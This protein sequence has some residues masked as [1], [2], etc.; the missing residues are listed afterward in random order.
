[1]AR[2]YRAYNEHVGVPLTPYQ[3]RRTASPTTSFRRSSQQSSHHGQHYLDQEY[4]RTYEQNFKGHRRDSHTLSHTPPAYATSSPSS[5][6]SGGRSGRLYSD[7]HR[8]RRHRTRCQTRGRSR[9]PTRH[10]FDEREANQEHDRRHEHN[11]SARYRERDRGRSPTSDGFQDRNGIHSSGRNG[12]RSSSANARDEVFY[13]RGRRSPC[14]ESHGDQEHVL[15]SSPSLLPL[16]KMG[17]SDGIAIKGIAQQHSCESGVYYVKLD[18]D[19]AYQLQLLLEMEMDSEDY[20]RQWLHVAADLQDEL[21][22]DLMLDV[23]YGD[24]N[25]GRPKEVD[26]LALLRVTMT[27]LV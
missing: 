20:P 18:D 19:C 22:S 16:C 21:E 2:Q 27:T 12:Q 26:W 3:S 11:P 15:H 25:E 6:S 9:S 14:E 23:M 4:T 17:S 1:M 13:G 5:N 8:P 10:L 7:V 24:P